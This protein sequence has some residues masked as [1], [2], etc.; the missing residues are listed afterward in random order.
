MRQRKSTSAAGSLDG[1][2]EGANTLDGGGPGLSS[3][4]QIEYEARIAYC[5]PAEAGWRS[6]TP[7]QELLDF[8]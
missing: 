4:A 5:L 8:T 3:P 7:I 6:L 1:L 2:Q